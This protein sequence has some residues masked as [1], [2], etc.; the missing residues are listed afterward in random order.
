MT[1]QP[2]YANSWGLY[3]T[4]TMV[5]TGLCNALQLKVAFFH[6]QWAW[7]NIFVMA[8]SVGGMLLYFYILSAVEL[9]FLNVANHLY[10]AEPIFW[11]F[12]FFTIPFIVIYIDVI[13]YYTKVVFMPTEEMVF[14]EIEV[15]VSEL[16][17]MA[18]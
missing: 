7:P 18:D 6:H 3:D 10:N 13:G 16:V 15:E 17:A 9:D 5:F 1:L 11:F 12:G 14:K 8:I 2:T 4:G